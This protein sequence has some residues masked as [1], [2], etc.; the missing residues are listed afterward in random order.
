MGR[1]E[2]LERIFFQAVFA[3]DERLRRGEHPGGESTNLHDTPAPSM[4]RNPGKE[5]SEA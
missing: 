1:N 5:A 3:A 4:G 2:D